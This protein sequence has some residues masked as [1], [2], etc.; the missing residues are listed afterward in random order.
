VLSYSAIIDKMWVTNWYYPALKV[1]EMSQCRSFANV[2]VFVG[3]LYAICGRFMFDTLKSAETY[4]PSIE[5]WTSIADMHLCQAHAGKII[6]FLKK[7][8]VK[9]HSI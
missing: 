2:A 7:I 6:I 8:F 3:K 1:A 5:V 4:D 9:I